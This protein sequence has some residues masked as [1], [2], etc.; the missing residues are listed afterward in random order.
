MPQRGMAR[1]GP[2]GGG[3]GTRH[4]CGAS[5]RASPA[6][7]RLPGA[8]RRPAAPP[9]A[10]AGRC[11][12]ARPGGGPARA[13]ARQTRAPAAA[14][15]AAL[16][17][18][19]QSFNELFQQHD[20]GG[21][22]AARARGSPRRAR[23]VDVHLGVTCPTEY[24][25]SLRVVG[26]GPALG[27]WDVE[28][29]PRLVWH[30]GNVWSARVGLPPGASV[31]FKYVLMHC[32]GDAEWEPGSNRALEVPA[33]A[34]ALE[35]AAA[36]GA[37]SE[38]DVL[39][40]RRSS[41]AAGG[42]GRGGAAAK[43]ARPQQQRREQQQQQQQQQEEASPARSALDELLDTIDEDSEHLDQQALLEQEQLLRVLQQWQRLE[44]REAARRGGAADGAGADGATA[45]G[46]GPPRRRRRS[47]GR[48]GR[49]GASSPAR[50]RCAADAE[51]DGAAAAAAAAAALGRLQ[52]DQDEE[53]AHMAAEASY[54]HQAAA[55]AAK[56]A[57]AVAA[58]VLASVD[59]AS[60]SDGEAVTVEELAAAEAAAAAAGAAAGA[61][62]DAAAVVRAGARAGALP[63]L[64]DAQ[65]A[66]VATLLGM[67][68]ELTSNIASA[69]AAMLELQEEMADVQQ[70]VARLTAE[71]ILQQQQQQQQQQQG[72]LG[73][74][75]GPAFGDSGIAAAL[76][77]GLGADAVGDWF[78]E[79]SG[80]DDDDDVVAPAAWL[81]LA[82]EARDD[83]EAEEE[84]DGEPAPALSSRLGQAAASLATSDLTPA[85]LSGL[86][87]AVLN[88]RQELLTFRQESLLLRAELNEL[89]DSLS[90]V[91]HQLL[92][93]MA[94]LQGLGD[95]DDDDAPGAAPATAGAAP[96]PRVPRAAARAAAAAEAAEAGGRSAARGADGAPPPARR[97]APGPER[98][99]AAPPPP[100]ALA[101]AAPARAASPAYEELMSSVMSQLWTS[102]PPE[103]LESTLAAELDAAA[104]SAQAQAQAQVQAGVDAELLVSRLLGS[105]HAQHHHKGLLLGAMLAAGVWE[106]GLHHLV[107]GEPMRLTWRA[108]KAAW[109][110][111]AAFA[112]KSQLVSPHA[113]IMA[114]RGLGG[115][116]D[117]QLATHVLW[118]LRELATH[119]GKVAQLLAR[120]ADEEELEVLERLRPGAVDKRC[121][122]ILRRWM[123]AAGRSGPTHKREMAP[124]R[125][126]AAWP[127][128]AL[129]ALLAVA[130][131]GGGSAARD[132]D[133]DGTVLV[134][135]EEGADA[136][137]SSAGL[138]ALA[139][140][141][142][143]LSS[144]EPL[145]G[146]RGW[147][148]CR[149]APAA[150]AEPAA[151]DR[152]IAALSSLEG[153]LGASPPRA[154]AAA[155]AAAAPRRRTFRRVG[156]G[157]K[158]FP[159]ARRLAQ[160]D[161]AGAANGLPP[162]CAGGS[163][164]RQWGIDRIRAPQAWTALA[165]AGRMP[166]PTPL[167]RPLGIVDTGADFLNNNVASQVNTSASATITAPAQQSAASDGGRAGKSNHGTHVFGTAAGAWAGG[168][169]SGVAG[170]LGP[171]PGSVVV[172]NPFGDNGDETGAA[173]SD[174][175]KCLAHVRDVGAGSVV[176]LS[177]GGKWERGSTT[178]ALLRD[179]LRAVCDAGG[180]VVVAAH[181]FGANVD[182]P[183][184]T[185]AVYPAA[186]AGGAAFASGDVPCLL[187]VAAIDRSDQL[188]TFSNWGTKVAIAAPGVDIRSCVNSNG[189]AN[190]WAAQLMSGTSMASPHVAG[191]ASLL[192]NAFPAASAGDV[193]GCLTSTAADRVGL[194]NF[195]WLPA[196]TLGGG[197]LNVEAAYRCLLSAQGGA[198]PPDCTA[199]AVPPCVDA[200][201][202]VPDAACVAGPGT[203]CLAVGGATC[204][205]ALAS[206]ATV[207]DAASGTRCTGAAAACP[208]AAPVV[209]EAPTAC[210][211]DARQRCELPGLCTAAQGCRCSAAGP[212]CECNAALGFVPHRANGSAARCR[213]GLTFRGARLLEVPL[214]A[215]VAI[216]LSLSAPGLAG[217]VCPAAGARVVASVAILDAVPCPQ[218]PQKRLAA[219]AGASPTA[220]GGGVAESC[221]EVVV[222]TAKA[223]AVAGA[224]YRVKVSTTDRRSNDLTF[225][226]RRAAMSG[227][228][229][230]PGAAAKAANLRK[231]A[232]LSGA[233]GLG[234]GLQPISDDDA[235]QSG[236]D[237]SRLSL[238]AGSRAPIEQHAWDEYW[239]ER[240]S[241][242]LPGRGSFNVYT[243]GGE[244][245][246][247]LCLHG[248]GY[249]GLTWSLVARQL[250][251]RYR[252]VAPDLRGHGDTHTAD[253]LDFSAETMTRDIVELWKALFGGAPART[254]TLVVGHSMGGA[255]GVWAAATR[256]L[257][258]LDGVAVIDVVEGTALAALPHMMGV[259]H[260]R[261]AAFPSMQAAL[262]WAVRS[263]TCKNREMAGVSL[264]SQLVPAPDGGGALAWRTPLAASRPHWEGWY[265]GLSDAFLGLPVPKM[266]LLAG[267]DRLDRSLTIGQMQ[268]K[269]QLVLMPTAGHA[270]QEDEP[271]KTSEYLQQFLHRQR[272]GEPPMVIPRAA[273]G[274]RPVLPV[275]GGPLFAKPQALQQQPPPLE[276]PPEQPPPLEASP[277]QPRSAG[278][279]SNI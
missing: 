230:P 108:Y 152:V 86:Q 192:R 252:V 91:E 155:A 81:E 105:G 114:L 111:R 116:S 132:A 78:G 26:A 107:K 28:R 124:A 54:M 232:L 214:D 142:Q 145:P 153:G 274:V 242:E 7:A 134:Q 271:L 202:G 133:D 178:A 58:K 158:L 184:D 213:W 23:D 216:P 34:A 159:A 171:A 46:S 69:T 179:A 44:Q 199:Q 257:P 27:D 265:R 275:V 240:R 166:L 40:L 74:G 183:A 102:V 267:T 180:L 254:P 57:A 52:H 241:L 177:L 66:L 135:L 103:Q 236:F 18:A 193:L 231:Q 99:A 82:L 125:R 238:D 204:R 144:C 17:E 249:T 163:C 84:A 167:P 79:S 209:P 9:G 8:S 45:D 59:D 181:N 279:Q 185:K 113:V 37:T 35:V 90:T 223:G 157:K 4:A 77:A 70:E 6:P 88:W 266:L 127:A 29:G 14:A 120:A 161:G 25:Q 228:M 43:P 73:G 221:G 109:S 151:A 75:D 121:A 110:D 248:G 194:K 197:V 1:P 268:G 104:A 276:P 76:M 156:R 56:A 61:A 262:E 196:A 168:D 243:A 141:K 95:I 212:D 64:A 215:T 93:N 71:R 195:D 32:S 89:R 10:T 100:A 273:P 164:P 16:G 272:I 246:V 147:A 118:S 41:S 198:A 277:E 15:P 128:A 50:A 234:G 31:E 264:P 48:R 22:D 51:A 229:K 154:G 190:V 251:D 85:A 138:A 269:F 233:G 201:S 224:C 235:V 208:S 136:T 259:L 2:P 129:L 47:A 115:A 146:V 112:W 172:C 182:D 160:A 244:G 173:V 117:A 237:C 260:S 222:S 92:T 220:A 20:E 258:G 98:G 256:E 253:D 139:V 162:E 186:F 143:E 62:A 218:R 148:A 60:A 278:A 24:G 106:D 137:A 255:L 206:S 245:A 205:Y 33:S 247:V 12:A 55:A 191:A 30:E 3:S 21:W 203:H 63:A 187:A 226:Y 119:S 175:V 13:A 250:K 189:G 165:A 169:A 188:A 53:L 101:P 130:L 11:G 96:A 123:T 68:A 126:G 150:A 217:T 67:R 38:T 94:A 5:A 176:N 42:S 210:A 122:A 261:P 239:D 270:I 131:I 225:I 97:E 149:L 36:W 87:S 83:D 170:V 174:I 65:E 19:V 227:V 219:A 80:S 140:G 39:E 207:C 72:A 49:S 200:A 263:G 211:A